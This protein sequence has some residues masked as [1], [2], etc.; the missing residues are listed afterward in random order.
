MQTDYSFVVEGRPKAKQ[1]PRL[2]KRGRVFTPKAT[3]EAEAALRDTYCGPLYTGP[4][5]LYL[6]F[7]YGHTEITL[8][9]M[10]WDSPLRGDVDN[11]VK[12][13]MDG[14]QGVAYANDRQIVRLE[15][16]KR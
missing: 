5:A 11:Y 15:A 14:L 12:T 2:T 7:E 10:R 3:M 1:R 4:L 6:T 8:E 13:V 9:P 16:D